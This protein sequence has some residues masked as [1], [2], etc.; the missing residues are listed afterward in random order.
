MESA[1]SSYQLSFQ[2][3][4]C[5]FLDGGRTQVKALHL[6][7]PRVLIY[8][9]IIITSHPLLGKLEIVFKHNA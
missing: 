8:K 5:P 6:F 9:T 2:F 7:S 3:Q 1:L 4:F